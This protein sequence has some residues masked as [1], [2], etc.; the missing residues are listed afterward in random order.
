MND[1]HLIMKFVE[2]P[3]KFST[4]ADGFSGNINIVFLSPTTE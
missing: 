4:L 2:I 3:F 1:I